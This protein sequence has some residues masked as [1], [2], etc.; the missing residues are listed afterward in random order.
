V[1]GLSVDATDFLELIAGKKNAGWKTVIAR[2]AMA[3][4]LCGR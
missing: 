2:V 4:I 3:I 1:E